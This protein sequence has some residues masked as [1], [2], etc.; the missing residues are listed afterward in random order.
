MRNIKYIVIHCSATK[1][2]ID[3][4]AADIDLWHKQKGYQCIGYHFVIRLNGLVELGRSVSNVG[5]H[6]YGFNKNSIGICYIGGLNAKNKP[7]DTRTPE[8]KKS[9]YNLIRQ[10]KASFP[11]AQ[12]VG[13]RDLSPD[14]NHNG[15]IEKIEYLKECPCFDVRSEY[16][17][18]SFFK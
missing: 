7:C 17:A 12:I 6:V 13:H 14:I 16:K 3:Y 2:N 10:L 9:L 18:F 8:Q 5:A 11:D 15:I 1:E 4:K